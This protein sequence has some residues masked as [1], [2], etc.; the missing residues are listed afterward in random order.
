MSYEEF[1]F[2]LSDDDGCMCAYTLAIVP[3]M[4]PDSGRPWE[5]NCCESESD[6]LPAM[7][8]P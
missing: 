6:R 5:S 1:K 2:R 4:P 7:T 3:L 8:L